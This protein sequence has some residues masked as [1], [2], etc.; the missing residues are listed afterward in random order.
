MFTVPAN[1]KA[2]EWKWRKISNQSLDEDLSVGD[3]DND[4]D[5][6]LFQG[7]SWL[8]NPGSAD[9]E[10]PCHVIGQVTIPGSEPDRNDLFDFNGDGRLDAAVIYENQDRAATWRVHVIDSDPKDQIDHHDGTV[11]VDL[12]G[13]GDRDV[14]SIGW[15]NPKVWIF[16]NKAGDD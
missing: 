16:E 15:Y 4:G 3:I 10:W 5:L 11:I 14:V 6:D 8:E 13:D 2:G 1:P 12:D 7:T 9:S